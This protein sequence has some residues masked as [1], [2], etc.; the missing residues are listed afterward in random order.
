MKT[1]AKLLI[2]TSLV[3]IFSVGF[4]DCPNAK[5]E[6]HN[7]DT[8]DGSKLGEVGPTPT[9]AN[10]WYC[11]PGGENVS[12]EQACQ[13]VKNG[14]HTTYGDKCGSQG[15]NVSTPAGYYLARVRSGCPGD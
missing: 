12:Q 9:W 1:F 7:S 3:G 6:C 11:Y 2:A 13:F 5:F 8:P 14:C 10:G 4:A 15:C